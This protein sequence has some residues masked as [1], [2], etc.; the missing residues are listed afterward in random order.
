VVGVI[1]NLTLWFALHVLFA[2]L[3]EQQFGV[4]SILM[5]EPGSLDIKA[6]LLFA[7][8]AALLF[9]KNIG[10]IPVIGSAMALS[11]IAFWLKL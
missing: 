1:A 3:S 4:G 7:L 2:R 5:P 8:A 9:W 6:V 10:V 11:Q